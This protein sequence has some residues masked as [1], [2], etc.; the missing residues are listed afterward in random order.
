MKDPKNEAARARVSEALRALAADPNNGIE[1]ILDR[2]AIAKLGGTDEADFWVNLRSGYST[3]PSLKGP[4]IE[5]VKTRG[6]HGY[7]PANPDVN[8][9]FLIAGQ[10]IRKGADLG[11][12]DMRAIAPT[13][14]RVLKIP[15][16]TAGVSALDIEGR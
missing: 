12:I 3:H 13:V 16:P 6:T 15:F 11:E 7:S 5:A 10:G 1:Q 8:S 2:R 14:A 9:F 4:I